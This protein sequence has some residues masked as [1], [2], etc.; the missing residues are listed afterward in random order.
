MRIKIN[1]SGRNSRISLL[2]AVEKG[3]MNG[4]RTASSSVSQP[5]GRAIISGLKRFSWN[6]SFLVF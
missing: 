2:R 1:L 4:V 5:P 3:V 6:L